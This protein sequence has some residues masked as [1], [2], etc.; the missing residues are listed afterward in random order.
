MVGACCAGADRSG[1]RPFRNHGA[2]DWRAHTPRAEG[3]ASD[4]LAAPG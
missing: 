2:E 4:C 1:H 3:L